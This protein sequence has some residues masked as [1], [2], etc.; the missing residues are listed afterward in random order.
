MGRRAAQRRSAIVRQRQFTSIDGVLRSLDVGPNRHWPFLANRCLPS[1]LGSRAD[2]GRRTLQ[3][4]ATLGVVATIG[5]RYVEQRQ[6]YATFTRVSAR[7]A[8][9]APLD[10]AC[11]A[12]DA[13]AR[14]SSS[15]VGVVAP[16]CDVDVDTAGRCRC[17]AGVGRCYCRSF[18]IGKSNK[19]TVELPAVHFLNGLI[20]LDSKSFERL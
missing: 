14:R 2:Y 5:A 13:L 11:R 3:V 15:A 20:A 19:H 17:V 1:R 7:I 4:P 10:A 12:R 18:E 16:T 9:H 6:R 8:R